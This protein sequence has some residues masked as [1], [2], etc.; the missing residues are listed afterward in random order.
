LRRK[1]VWIFIHTYVLLQKIVVEDSGA[2]TYSCLLLVSSVPRFPLSFVYTFGAPRQH[3]VTLEYPM[4][5]LRHGEI[6]SIHISTMNQ[7][8]RWV[9]NIPSACHSFDLNQSILYVNSTDWFPLLNR[10]PHSLHTM[11][12]CFSWF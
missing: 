1:P 2:V 10:Y 8:C 3:K 9:F 6:G 5:P 7:L 11:P 12:Y 4:G